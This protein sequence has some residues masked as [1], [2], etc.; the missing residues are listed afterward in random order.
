MRDLLT[1]VRLK[2]LAV[3]L[4]MGIV[5]GFMLTRL[6]FP[7]APDH[8]IVIISGLLVFFSYGF[9]WIHKGRN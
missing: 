2:V 8:T 1:R 3:R 6:F 7:D 9:E 4:I 5:F